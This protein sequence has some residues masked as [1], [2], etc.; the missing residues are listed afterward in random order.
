VSVLNTWLLKPYLKVFGGD[1]S[2][3]SGAVGEIQTFNQGPNGIGGAYAGSGTELAAFAVNAISGFASAQNIGGEPLAVQPPNDLTFAN[4]LCA[5]GDNCYG[6]N[7]GNSSS[8]NLTNYTKVPLSA[9]L[10][11][12]AG[13]ALTTALNTPLPADGSPINLTYSVGGDGIISSAD[14]PPEDIDPS[15]GMP[16]IPSG[17]TLSFIPVRCHDKYK[18][19]IPTN[20]FK[21]SGRYA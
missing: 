10:A 20:A 11:N 15:N 9:T 5:S 21:R 14:F 16:F 12:D 2:A 6:G 18:Y 3:G 1:V 19:R 13:A 4:N 8:D 7:F 17:I